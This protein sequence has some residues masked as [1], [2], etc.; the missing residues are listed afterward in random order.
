MNRWFIAGAALVKFQE[1]DFTMQSSEK[2]SLR[3]NRV[4]AAPGGTKVKFGQV[5]AVSAPFRRQTDRRSYPPRRAESGLPAT[6]ECSD[7]GQHQRWP[8]PVRQLPKR[9]TG[10]A[11][12][13][14]TI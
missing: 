3:P 14:G 7:R 10:T 5:P 11:P 1:L 13:G 12:G 4:A 2:T 9:P 8:E 6:P